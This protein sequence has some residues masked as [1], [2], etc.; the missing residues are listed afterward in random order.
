[1]TPS[2]LNEKP[3]N[4]LWSGGWDS[5]FRLLFLLLVE[6]KKVKPYYIIDHERKSTPN[7]FQAMEA[8]KKDL[9]LKHPE[10]E[11]LLL[12]LIIGHRP[13]LDPKESVTQKWMELREEFKLGIQYGWVSLFA[14][15][16]GLHDLEFCIE[17]R[18]PLGRCFSKYKKDFVGKGHECRISDNPQDD[19]ITLFKFFRFPILH[20]TK[21]GMERV[22]RKH[23][24]LDILNKCWFCHTPLK[25]GKP[26][27]VCL[28]CKTAREA[29]YS[30]GLPKTNW[31]RDKCVRL[32]FWLCQAQGRAGDKG[33]RI[34]P[35]VARMT[36]SLFS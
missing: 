5:T 1:M 12:P 31:F 34:L 11:H 10:T 22:A 25:N 14:E 36:R 18:V 2:S 13:E 15:K 23:G 17:K 27:E 16:Q 33:R 6:K 4:L 20:V 29:G 28:P 35:K 19:I 9:F 8:I 24:F 30:H 26:C 7:E 3:I 21:P 32:K